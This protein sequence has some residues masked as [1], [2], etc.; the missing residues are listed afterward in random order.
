VWDEHEQPNDYARYTSFGLR[1]L[2]EG[3]GLKVLQHEKLGSDASI[4]FQLA[5][6]YLFKVS[7]GMPKPIKLLMTVTL[8]AAINLLGLLARRLLP[9][10]PDLFL[11]HAVLAEKVS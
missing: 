9:C 4:L 3:K 7:Q 10:N 6:A 5:N 11:D 8:M 2:L 1:A